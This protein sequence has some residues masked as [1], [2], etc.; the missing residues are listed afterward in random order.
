MS[1]PAPALTIAELAYIA[2]VVDTIGLIRIRP[3]AEIGLPTV[4]VH[5]KVTPSLEYLATVTGVRLTVIHRDFTRAG[6]MEHCPEQ[7]QHVYS[8]S[9]RWQLTGS[10]ATIALLGIRQFLRIQGE[11]ADEAIAIG[12]KAGRKPAIAAK[13]AALGW[14]VPEDWDSPS[15]GELRL[16]GGE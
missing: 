6:C 2:G 3:Y 9:G 13:M 7:H 4:M 11:A 8:V 5:A 15:P 1:S 10:R 12:L 16:V 14:P